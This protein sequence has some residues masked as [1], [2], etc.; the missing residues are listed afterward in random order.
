VTISTTAQVTRLLRDWQSGDQQAL[1]RLI[2]LVYDELHVIASRYASREWRDGALQPTALVNEAYV[3]LV[4]QHDVNWQ[5]RAHFFAVAAQIMRR[6][7]LDDARGRLRDKRGGGAIAV[8][9]EG[10]AAAVSMPP[11]HPADLIAI[12]D[13]L[14]GLEQVDPE[15]ARLVELRF[16]AGL[17]IEE[18]AAVLGSSPAS[19]KREWAIA[20]GWLRRA[21]TGTGAAPAAG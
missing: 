7:L 17:T 5:N 9:L 19:V 8:D 10:V 14:T 1:E 13:A 2:P 15:Q 11:L 6:I 18:T 3:K 16:Y 20:K 12:D 21:L 4:D